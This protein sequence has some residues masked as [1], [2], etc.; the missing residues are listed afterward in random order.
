MNLNLAVDRTWM[1]DK[2][3]V[4]CLISPTL[5]WALPSAVLAPAAQT[6]FPFLFLSLLPFLSL[7]FL[8]FLLS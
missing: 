6:L 7:R 2:L 3:L 5:C 8:L 4:L 1:S